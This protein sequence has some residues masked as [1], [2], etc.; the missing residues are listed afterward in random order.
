MDLLFTLIVVAYT[1]LVLYRRY[2]EDR[3][4]NRGYMY[5]LAALLAVS[6]GS[7]LTGLYDRDAVQFA[8]P[9]VFFLIVLAPELMVLLRDSQF[10]NGRFEYAASIQYV[11]RLLVW[12]TSERE[13]HA[14]AEIARD[15]RDGDADRARE[16]LDEL[17]GRQGRPDAV[18]DKLVQVRILLYGQDRNWVAVQREFERMNARRQ[19]D[20]WTPTVIHVAQAGVETDRF[21]LTERMLNI[22][23][24][25]SLSEQQ[26]LAAQTVRLGYLMLQG[27]YDAGKLL[28][29]NICEEYEEAIPEAYAAYWKA[30][31]CQE[32]GRFDEAQRRYERALDLVEQERR[33][34]WKQ[35]IQERMRE[36]EIARNRS[37]TRSG[38][39]FQGDELDQPRERTMDRSLESIPEAEPVDEMPDQSAPSMEVLQFIEKV[40]RVPR[41]TVVL[42]VVIG[43]IFLSMLL[44]V[45]KQYP[46][47]SGVPDATRDPIALSVFGMKA[48]YMIDEPYET[49]SVQPRERLQ[50]ARNVLSRDLVGTNDLST[51]KQ[52]LNKSISGDPDRKGK[53]KDQDVRNLWIEA[54]FAHMFG[55][56]AQGGIDFPNH[57]YW[58]LVTCTLLHIGW[59]HLLL[60]GYALWI[61]GKL[62]ENIYGFDDFLIIYLISG[63][64]GSIASWKFGASPASAGASGA[65]FGLLGAAISLTIIKKEGVP[66]QIRSRL[67]GPLVFWTIVN[68]LLGFA[69]TNIDNAGHIGGMVGGLV[70]GYLL[71]S[72]RSDGSRSQRGW[73]TWVKWSVL[74]LLAGIYLWAI[75]KGILFA[76]EYVPL[77]P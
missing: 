16:A 45:Q 29:E 46:V 12:S 47:G 4:G 57:Q 21:E 36:L 13:I 64:T 22:L 68:L 55:Y 72:R 61:L 69:I 27:Q 49:G 51:I 37:N 14:L 19:Q 33:L 6:L 40:N 39:R 41:A 26:K 34:D 66:E 42:L 71:P 18:S 70:F 76:I 9:L 59:I 56:T 3:E 2:Q 50:E 48:D 44:A 17:G 7:L 1:G 8:L 30:R 77:I 73:M 15:I 62:L 54:R 58:R 32:I 10:R 35:V 20:I 31:G 38:Y 5:V 25:R 65:I 11:I 52:E 67:A 24:G 63:L 75:Y 74:A 60:N 43:G 23:D 53:L 28:I